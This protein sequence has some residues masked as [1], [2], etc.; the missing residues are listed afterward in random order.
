MDGRT[1]RATLRWIVE[2]LMRVKRRMDRDRDESR[3]SLIIVTRNHELALIRIM[4]LESQMIQVRE[5]VDA[6]EL[7]NPTTLDLR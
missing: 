5:N 3:A 4:E 2:A 6:L 1:P 7:A